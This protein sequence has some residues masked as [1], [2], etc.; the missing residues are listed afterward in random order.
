VFRPSHLKR[1]T[2]YASPR[3]VSEDDLWF[4]FQCLARGLFVI[5]HG[6]EDRSTERYML[7]AELVHFDLKPENSKGI[8]MACKARGDC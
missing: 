7:G 1:L 6:S 3:N 4:I 8:W 5:H 2:S